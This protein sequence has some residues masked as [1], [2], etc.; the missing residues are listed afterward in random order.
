VRAFILES[1]RPF[2]APD[3]H[4]VAVELEPGAGNHVAV[5]RNFHE[6]IL[7]G[8]PLAAD[9]AEGRMSLELANAM[10]YSSHTRSAVDLPLDRQK[11][12]ALLEELKAQVR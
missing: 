1:Q 10:V 6:A 2:S 11:Y 3:V 7:H 8:A 12:A 5:Y 4:P 9:G